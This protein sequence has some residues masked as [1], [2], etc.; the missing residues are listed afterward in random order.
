MTHAAESGPLS[1]L[2]GSLRTLMNTT[3]DTAVNWPN[4]TVT[5]ALA[6]I[7]ELYTTCR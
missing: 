4:E 7:N 3:D 2:H 1:R 6:K 5:T